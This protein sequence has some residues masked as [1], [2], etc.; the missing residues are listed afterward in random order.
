MMALRERVLVADADPGLRQQVYDRLTDARV[1]V[2]CVADGRRALD[3]LRAAPYA[4]V[5][6]DVSLPLIGAE[7]VLQFIRELPSSD[8][9]VVLV[10]GEPNAVRSLDVDLIQIV[11]RKPCNL[12]HIAELVQSCVAKGELRQVKGETAEGEAAVC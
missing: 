11:I 4:V 8:R 6:L 7:R 9:P 10:L 12:T 2:D 3:S 5:L 1:V